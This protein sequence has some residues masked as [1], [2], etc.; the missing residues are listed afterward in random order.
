[1]PLPSSMT[2][3]GFRSRWITPRSC[4]AARPAHN[5]RAI[6]S[7]LSSGTGRCGEAARTGLPHPRTPSSGTVARRLRRCRT[8]GRRCGCETCRPSGLRYETVRAAR[9]LLQRGRQ[10]L[11]R[12]RLAERRSSARYTS[13]MP[14]RP[15]RPMT[16][17][18]LLKDRPGLK[19]SVVDGSPTIRASRS[20][21]SGV[22]G[23]SRV[24][25]PGGLGGVP[26]ARV[27]WSRQA[28]LGQDNPTVIC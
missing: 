5:W 26:P 7:A 27:L 20:N 22:A 18:Q 24:S 19:P 28:W 15:S 10:E 25:S 1:L 8:R 3:A 16:R 2:F 14:P 23:E 9:I 17:Y 21:D 13:P 4:A 11:Q 12:D 6:S